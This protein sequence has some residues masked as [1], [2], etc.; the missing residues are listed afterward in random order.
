MW[1]GAEVRSVHFR[2]TNL[3]QGARTSLPIYGYYMNKVYKDS[4]IGISTDDFE[5]P[6]NFKLNTTNCSGEYLPK[7]QDVDSVQQQ[8]NKNNKRNPFSY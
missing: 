5:A 2:S 7:D 6:N 4:K 8:I 3:G 1:V